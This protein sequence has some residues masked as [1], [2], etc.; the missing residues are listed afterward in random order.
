MGT[1]R[2]TKH[3]K[4]LGNGLAV[5][6]FGSRVGKIHNS[7]QAGGNWERDMFIESS[8]FAASAITGSLA[9]DAGLAIL[10]FATPVGWFGL[11][12]G[13]VA[14]GGVAAAASMGM[15]S[16][17]KNNSGNVYDVIMKKLNN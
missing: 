12:I 14:V 16:L 13:G 5:I 7:Y 3:A 2:L 1:K 17:M 9:V 10:I 4:F 15:N 6:E 8:S 11:I